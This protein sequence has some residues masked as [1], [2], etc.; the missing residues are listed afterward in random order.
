MPSAVSV[1]G[2]RRRHAGPDRPRVG[3][4][5]DLWEEGVIV[6]ARCC[7]GRRQDG[8]TLIEVLIAVML[9]G[10]VII[11][12]AAGMLT[13][14]RST[15]ATAEEQRLQAALA[16]FTESLR[17]TDY[18]PCSGSPAPTAG[19]YEAAHEAMSGHWDPAAV[20]GIEDAGITDVD[21]WVSSGGY[22]E[23]QDDCPTTGDEGRQLLTVRVT[24]DGGE[25]S[26]VAQ[27][28]LSDRFE[29]ESGGNP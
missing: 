11:A 16:S 15:R 6:G 1:A 21:H 29:V 8:Y 14:M 25:R 18:L 10:T 20:D 13:M 5:E 7:R 19:S 3:D 26:G 22:G 24:L 28:V 23:Y 17:A 27:V 12:V 2:V 4:H 9:V